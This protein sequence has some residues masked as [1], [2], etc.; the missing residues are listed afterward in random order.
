[1]KI[2]FKKLKLNVETPKYNKLG[3]AGMDLKATSIRET[4]DYIEYGTS[5]ALEI[6]ENYVGLVFSR[7]SI[8]DYDLILKNAVAVLDSNFRG[9]VKL[10]FQNV[11]DTNT[12]NEEKKVI[13]SRASLGGSNLN[14]SIYKV[15]DRIGQLIVMPI[16]SIELEEVEELSETVRGEGGFGSSGS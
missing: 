13:E 2:K 10:R 12:L 5:I 14:G 15:G 16:P 4:N 1:M 9:E 7:S 8:T 11:K 3:D 6:P